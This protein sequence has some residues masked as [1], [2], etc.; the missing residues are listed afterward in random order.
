[1][2]TVY[3]L[4]VHLWLLIQ[5]DCKKPHKHPHGRLKTWGAIYNSLRYAFGLYEEWLS[6]DMIMLLQSY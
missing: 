3:S 2:K 6:D 4:Y 5:I 1:M